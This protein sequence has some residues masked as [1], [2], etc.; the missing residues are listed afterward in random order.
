VSGC[1]TKGSQPEGAAP[2]RMAQV[3]KPPATG[4]TVVAAWR[5]M[6][7]ARVAWETLRPMMN[8]APSLGGSL[9]WE[10]RLPMAGKGPAAVV[11]AVRMPTVA[12]TLAVLVA[13]R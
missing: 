12:P 8:G 1:E 9:L 2:S 5:A 6:C 11:A 13:N 4:V 10:M 3:G 7:A